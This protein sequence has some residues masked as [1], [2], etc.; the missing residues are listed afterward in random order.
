[1]GYIFIRNKK[2]VISDGIVW[3]GQNAFA[4]LSALQSVKLG[5]F[6]TDIYSGAFKGCTSLSS[7]IIPESVVNIAGNAFNGC[8][9]LE[10]IVIPDSV[11]TVGD[12]AFENCTGLL[13]VTIGAKVDANGFAFANCS[14]LKNLTLKNGISNIGNCMF[15]N[16][17]SLSN[18]DIPSSVTTIYG[19]AFQ[20]CTALSSICMTKNI[21]SIGFSA[22][23]GCQSLSSVYFYG[24]VQDRNNIKIDNLHNGNSFLTNAIWMYSEE[25]HTH[26]NTELRNVKEATC[27][28]DGYTG[29]TH[30]IDCGEK[31]S[32]GTATPATNN[33]VDADGK[34]ETDSTNHWHTCYY[35]TTFDEAE[36][37]GGMAT[38]K[39]KAVCK[40]C[41]VEYGDYATHNLTW[42]GRVEPT[43]ENDGNIEYWTCNECGKYFSDAEGKSE[44]AEEDII[45][46]KIGSDNKCGENVTWKF[47]DSTG[48]LTI[49]GTG[50]MFDYQYDIYPGFI[51]TPWHDLSKNKQIKRVI[52]NEGVTSIGNYAFGCESI[53]EISIPSTVMKIGEAAFYY[54]AISSIAL[55]ENIKVLSRRV[56]EGCSNLTEIVIPNGVQNIDSFAFSMCDNLSIV[57]IPKSII[58][59]KSSAFEFCEKLATVYYDG[60]SKNRESITI[61]N[62]NDNLEN[63][64]W[65][66]AQHQKVLEEHTTDIVANSVTNSDGYA[67]VRVNGIGDIVW[68]AEKRCYIYS[69]TDAGYALVDQNG[70][71][72]FDYRTDDVIYDELRDKKLFTSYQY[73]DGLVAPVNGGYVVDNCFYSLD[74]KI[75]YKIPSLLSD[76]IFPEETED[77]R[78]VIEKNLHFDEITVFSDGIAVIRETSLISYSIPGAWGAVKSKAA[79]YLVNKD[80]EITYVFP[81]E[82]SYIS[83][84]TMDYKYKTSGAGEGLLCI[85]ISDSKY[86]ESSQS[87][88]NVGELVGYID[89]SGNTVLTPQGY[90]YGGRF[91]EGLAI[92][93]SANTGK[94][95]FI[96]KNG[97][98]VIACQFDEYSGYGFENGYIAVS[99]DGKWG[100]ID[101]SGNTIIPFVYDVAYGGEKGLFSV[102]TNGK[103]GIVNAENEIVIP[104]EYDN[105]TAINEGVCYAVKNSKLVIFTLNVEK[106]EVA[107][108]DG[109][110]LIDIP[111]NAIP[112]N[113]EFTVAKIV[114]PPAE[115]V[116]KVK[117]TYGESSE[118]LAYY[119]I[120][121]FDENGD[122]I[123]KLDSEITIKSILPEKYQTG[124]VIKINQVDDGGNLVEMESWREGEFI[125][126]KTDWLEKYQ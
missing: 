116:E 39:A 113:A 99:K 25:T 49:S 87:W 62:G 18:I 19:Q 85:Y 38:C 96:N 32:S 53:V 71:I 51:P 73:S 123:Y 86:D 106:S 101:K 88:V 90:S 46:N 27:C 43:F 100:Y 13:N 20:G 30:C 70:N 119:E 11:L 114:P 115:I 121:L 37:S 9:S 103:C 125:C 15:Q 17:T 94:Y 5:N 35:G 21:S 12:H 65:I 77:E 48:T 34:W 78:Y 50:D 64:T 92:V 14:S 120:R 126:Y 124:Y 84:S 105:I 111:A 67:S 91:C 82:Y 29:D 104:L 41:G 10:S 47:D 33:H 118:V 61:A 1:M 6:T 22:F 54:T 122:R 108:L 66:Y 31:L 69:E 98:E 72:V 81:D 45:I 24:N 56:F 79:W 59:I 26:I 4:N 55:P 76:Y 60:T 23:E 109:E 68:D 28:E 40:D 80:G 102:E 58:S 3:I 36:H 74:G 16:C 63:A 110:V 95:G 93:K 57:T 107:F 8:A 112:E 117:D 52:I 75:A 97:E 44:I 2:V 83:G 89:Y 7:I 42:H